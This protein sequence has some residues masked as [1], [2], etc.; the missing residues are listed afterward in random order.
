MKTLN[1]P[2]GNGTKGALCCAKT[3][4]GGKCRQ[5]AMPNG[6][7]YYHGGK[8]KSG[9]EHGRYTNGNYT[10]RALA[11]RHYLTNLMRQSRALLGQIG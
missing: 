7:C 3:R 9:K 5:L 6:R 4:Q 11:V 8:S 2:M 10:K 1:Y